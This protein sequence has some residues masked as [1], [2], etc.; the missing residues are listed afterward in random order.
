MEKFRKEFW[1]GC[2]VIAVVILMGVFAWLMG[3]FRP[4]SN[5]MQVHLL[6]RFA[7]G[8]K[9][10]SPVRVAGVKVGKIDD[11]KFVPG[12]MGEESVP[13]RVTVSISKDASP[14]VRTDSR[15]YV[16]MAGIIG[17]RYIEITPGS[18]NKE[19]LKDG[20]TVR[21]V[22]PPRI[23]QLI[24]QGYGVFGKLQTL[25]EDNDEV[26]AEFLKE[27]PSV[28]ASMTKIMK[29]NDWRKLARLVDNVNAVA[30]DL[31]LMTSKFHNPE[32]EE[33]L[34]KLYIMIR[35]MYEIDDKAL[36]KFFQEEGIRTRIF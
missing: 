2:L 13:L 22:D 11:I 32:T 23:D 5:S 6:Y 12:G 31:R 15:F 34:D 33:T 10:G 9:E 30:S 1:V 3:A 17:E 24:S 21:G 14:T 19:N 18:P 8:V 27:L 29:N 20:D 36:K 7:G 16:N 28:L 25:L 26:I 4:F 35:R